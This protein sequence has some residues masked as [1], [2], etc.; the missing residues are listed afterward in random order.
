LRFFLLCQIDR[1]R[2]GFVSPR[3]GF[4]SIIFAGSVIAA[5]AEARELAHTATI[6]PI[7]FYW[8]FLAIKIVVFALRSEQ[9]LIRRIV[10]FGGCAIGEV[11]L[12]W[13]VRSGLFSDPIWQETTHSGYLMMAG[14]EDSRTISVRE[15]EDRS[16]DVDAL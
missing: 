10:I 3:I 2:I 5:V 1:A 15:T 12:D 13:A 6:H 4:A 8:V 14:R 11:V 7:V 9:P 16:F